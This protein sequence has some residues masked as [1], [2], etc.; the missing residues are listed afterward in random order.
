MYEKE[1]YEAM[2]FL[3]MT[4]EQRMTHFGFDTQNDL[5]DKIG[6]KP[7]LISEWK[8]NPKFK[9]QLE[10]MQISLVKD[11]VADIIDA[12]KRRGIVDGDVSALKELSKIAGIS[13]ER[14]QEVGSDDIQY[15]IQTVI[16]AANEVLHAHPALLAE[17][18]SVLEKKLGEV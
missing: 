11:D 5:A 14:T 15:A 16:E 17:F 10:R 2:I 9:K 13:I 6:V 4:R 8:A 1:K 18:V 12:L 7:K 3:T